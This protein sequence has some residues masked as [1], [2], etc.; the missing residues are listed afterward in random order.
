MLSDLPGHEENKAAL[1]GDLLAVLLAP[2]DD[3]GA[4]GDRVRISVPRVRVGE[5]AV[6]TLALVVHELATNS[7]KYG[8]LS[9]AGGALYVSCAAHDDEVIITWAERGGPP[10]AA[11]MGPAGF[12]SKLVTQSMSGQLGG[13]I[14]FDWPTE[15]VIVT[16]RMNK[17]RLAA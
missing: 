14:T 11:P 8:A 16:L 7:I 17:A 6:T 5:A 12:G 15:G 4:V 2:Y 1:L 3:K 10:V 9:A 13:S